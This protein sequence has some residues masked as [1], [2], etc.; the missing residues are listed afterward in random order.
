MGSGTSEH[1]FL[2]LF[3]EKNPAGW[4]KFDFK[5]EAREGRYRFQIFNVRMEHTSRTLVIGEDSLMGYDKNRAEELKES[6][7]EG[8]SNI[9]MF[10]EEA[11]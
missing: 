6:L 1:Y 9:P 7:T 11:W 4:W 3:G 8:F 10:I 2:G 5:I